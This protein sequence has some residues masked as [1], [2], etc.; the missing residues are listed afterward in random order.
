METDTAETLTSDLH[1]VCLVM[2]K[3]YESLITK[4]NGLVTKQLD[5][6]PTSSF[7][8]HELIE[9]QFEELFHEYNNIKQLYN[10]GR[11]IRHYKERN[12]QNAL[13]EIQYAKNV[14][15]MYATKQ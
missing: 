13:N 14:M 9:E 8:E 10:E 4:M 12:Q 5:I 3:S 6:S 1:A 15:A 7:E 11:M 2:M